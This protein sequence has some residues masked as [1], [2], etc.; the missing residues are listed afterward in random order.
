MALNITA[1]I[2]CPSPMK[3]TSNGI[4]QGDNPLDFALPL[5]ILQICLVVVLTRGLA[6]LLKPFKQPR[7]I[8]EIIVSLFVLLMQNIYS[9]RYFVCWTTK[10]IHLCI[11]KLLMVLLRGMLFS[12][13]SLIEMLLYFKC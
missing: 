3:A 9:F 7:V 8:G 1:V 10:L 11:V 4:F 2:K 13:Y 6:F 5:V 12:F